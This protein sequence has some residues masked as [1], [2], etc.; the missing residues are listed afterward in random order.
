MEL[1][2]I[3]KYI[4]PKY[5]PIIGYLSICPL[6]EVKELLL[7]IKNKSGIMYDSFGFEYEENNSLTF[8]DFTSDTEKSI[9]IQ[10]DEIVSFIEPIMNDY[11]TQNPSE[12]TFIKNILKE[13]NLF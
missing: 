2:K 8:Y 7:A 13:I 5:S 10:V 3:Y 6:Q 4:D 12:D 1:D 11:L 9:N